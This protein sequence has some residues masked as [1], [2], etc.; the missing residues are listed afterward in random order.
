MRKIKDVEEKRL[1]MAYSMSRIHGKSINE[2]FSVASVFIQWC[3]WWD[4]DFTMN[5][6]FK[7]TIY[8]DQLVASKES[9]K[10]IQPEHIQYYN[11]LLT[12]VR[13]WILAHYDVESSTR[14]NSNKFREQLMQLRADHYEKLSQIAQ[15]KSNGEYYVVDGSS[16]HHPGRLGKYWV[17]KHG[18]DKKHLYFAGTYDYTLEYL[19]KTLPKICGKTEK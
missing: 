5:G 11:K 16:V 1:Q 19:N 3:R 13:D 9:A 12:N 15:D 17:Y 14:D 8:Y 7:P 10:M 4:Y 6:G 2:K 18:E